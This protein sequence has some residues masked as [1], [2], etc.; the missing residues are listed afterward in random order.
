MES[1]MTIEELIQEI[2][3]PNLTSW[4]LFAKGSGVNVY[5]RT[6]DDHKLVQ[7]KCF[8]HIPDVTPEIFYKVALDVEYRLVWD[9]YLKEAKEISD[10]E[11][12]GVYWQVAMPLFIDNRDY[13]FVRDY[14]E[15]DIGSRHF[16]YAMTRTEPFQSIPPRK[17]IVR[18]ETCQSQTLL[19]SDGAKGLKS[20]FLYIEEP[21]GNVPKTLWTWVAK[22]GVP[23]Y[24]KLTHNAC[25]AYPNWIKDKTTK[26]PTVAEDEI[27]ETAAAAMI[28]VEN[29]LVNNDDDDDDEIQQEK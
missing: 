18:I 11:K 1:S 26:V 8:S 14:G 25:I 3:Q 22:F 10:G 23:M 27:D 5:R 17:K 12:N 28:T 9:K 29:D 2:D 24:S 20:V 6:D 19:C 16:Y 15:Y 4:K 13:T 7:Y 21:R